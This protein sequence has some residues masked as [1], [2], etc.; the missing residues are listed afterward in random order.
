[1]CRKTPQEGNLPEICLYFEG[2]LN[3]EK[4][5]VKMVEHLPW[6]ELEADYV[7]HFKSCGRGEVALNVRVA[8]EALLIKDILGLSDRGVVETM[9]ENPYLQY[10]LGFK[11][12]QMKAPFSASLL[13]HFRKR[14]V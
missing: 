12:F 7:K 11:I 8:I 9:S 2:R 1:M 13:T 6:N 10:F 5:W 14:L 3:P 4:R